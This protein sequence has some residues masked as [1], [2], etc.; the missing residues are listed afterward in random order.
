LLCSHCASNAQFKDYQTLRLQTLFGT[1]EAPRARYRCKECATTTYPIDAYWRRFSAKLSP[2][3]AEVAT[4]AGT[5]GSFGQAQ[6]A[7]SKIAGLS[8]CESLIEEL[9]QEC[10]LELSQRIED[11]EVFEPV[12]DWKWSQD[13]QG[14]R[15]GYVGVDGIH[16]PMQGAHA[17]KVPTR[18]AWVG[19]IYNPTW[20]NGQL[21]AQ[22]SQSRYQAGL[23]SLEAMGKRL[24]QQA[25]QLPQD[26]V[27]RW[28]CITDGGIGLEALL[29]RSFCFSHWILDFYHAKEY[30]VKLAQALWPDAEQRRAWLEDYC[31]C[32]KHSGGA[33]VLA[34]LEDLDL[35]GAPAAAR[36]SLET[37]L[38]YYRNHLQGMDY[39]YYLEMGWQIGSGPTEA[40]CRSVIAD[41]MK[42]SGMRWGEDGCHGM[43]H[44]RALFYNGPA[45]W[46][47]FW[48]SPPSRN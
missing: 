22:E 8:V 6:Q 11:G 10:G 28:I 47:R 20:K 23:F 7:L 27:D 33:A 39:P 44:L 25:Q 30:L 14:K 4:L 5:L 9:C 31:H 15:C 37:I 38:Q 41:R 17:E 18:V 34:R 42:H 1:V 29:E 35:A 36:E 21:Q 46:D 13:R 32:L 12:E 40:A 16:V 2:A 19:R 48:Q 45:S 24:Q 26:S 43:A 3:A